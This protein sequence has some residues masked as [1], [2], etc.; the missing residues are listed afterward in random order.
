[1][2]DAVTAH[3]P[4]EPQIPQ[5]SSFDMQELCKHFQHHGGSQKTSTGTNSCAILLIVVIA[6]VVGVTDGDCDTPIRLWLEVYMFTLAGLAFFLVIIQIVTKYNE[7]KRLKLMKISL[8]FNLIIN[9]FVFAWFI[10]GNVWYFSLD[11]C[12]DWPEGYRLTLVILLVQY[13]YL[14]AILMLCSCACALL[15]GVM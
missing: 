14:G 4:D 3:E 7:E 6:I 8:C 9:L 12:D 13:I 10:V 15:K 11:T 1:M 5:I 2:G